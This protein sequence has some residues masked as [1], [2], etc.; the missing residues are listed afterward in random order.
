MNRLCLISPE[1]RKSFIE[2]GIGNTCKGATIGF[3][4]PAEML[5]HWKLGK[6]VA[7]K[8]FEKML[9][10]IEIDVSLDDD[11][12]KYEYEIVSTKIKRGGEKKQCGF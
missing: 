2:G 4:I 1:S 9:D 11:F 8:L 12:G 5:S 7:K 10:A 3:V 6:E